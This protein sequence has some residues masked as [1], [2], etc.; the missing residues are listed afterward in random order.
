MR[1]FDRFERHLHHHHARHAGR[2]GHSH[3]HGFGGFGFGRHGFPDDLKGAFGRGRKLGSADLQL[4]LL[5]FLAEQPGHGYEL[6]QRFAERSNGYYT[7]SPGMVYPALAYLEDAG[8]ARVEMD[9]AKKRYA[10][11]PAGVEHLEKQRARVDALLEQLAWIGRRMDDLRRAVSGEDEEG[12]F[13][14]PDAFRGRGRYGHGVPELKQARRNLKSAI[15]EKFGAGADEQR[16]IADILNH[17]ADLIRDAGP[18]R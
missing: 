8:H 13:D 1:F 16:R 6:I 3:G 5:A 11:T 9:G 15:I 2:F 17:A 12:A 18:D 14:D 10:I 4:L 7:P